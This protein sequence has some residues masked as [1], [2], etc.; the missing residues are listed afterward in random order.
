[1][2]NRR[3]ALLSGAAALAAPALLTACGEAQP[4]VAAAPPAPANQAPGFYRYKVGSLT[5]TTVNDGYANFPLNGFVANKPLAEVQAVLR[6]NFQ[7]ED[8]LIVPFNVTFVETSRGLVAFDAGNGALAPTETRGKMIANMAAAGIDATKVVAV[9]VSHFHGDHISGLTN[10]EGLRAFPNAEVVVPQT[11]WRFWTDGG[12]ATRSPERQR[13]NFAN[14]ARRFQVYDGRVRVIRD[15]AEVMPG[16]R[17]VAA[18]GHTPGHTAYHIAD[19]NAEMIYVADIT[20]RPVPMALHPEFHAVVDFDPVM[21]EATR[22]RIYDRVATDRVA[23]TGYHFPF[24]AYGHMTREGNGY[25]FRLADW[26]ST[27]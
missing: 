24:P 3:T 15:N 16:I 22:R 6:A 11:E 13:G 27:V 7:P 1:M 14:T 5:V 10:A 9:V 12:N 23:I 18:H 8:R 2:L 25:R 19:G 17:A 4:V 20:N 26:Q 21:A